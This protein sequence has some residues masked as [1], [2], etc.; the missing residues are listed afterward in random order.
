MKIKLHKHLDKKIWNDDETMR[1]IVRD[2]LLSIAWAYI[3]Y[4]RNEYDLPIKNSDVKDILVVGSI[5]QLFYDKQ[6]DIDVAIVLDT[7][8]IKTK[9]TDINSLR[10]LKLYYYDWAMFHIC[11]IYGRKI[12]LNI[13]SK[14]D[15]ECEDRDV[16]G[17]NFSLLNNKWLFKRVSISE[18]ELIEVEKKA[19]D[20]YNK[21]LHDYK[22]IKSNKFPLEDI[23]NFYNNIIFSKRHEL[24][25]NNAHSI[26]PVYMAIRQFKHNGYI[27]KLR[28]IAIKKETDK[29]VLK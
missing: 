1:P 23:K 8:N 28:E 25:N 10:Q 18:Q 17:P 19:N 16:R 9:F 15:P 21:I 26:R 7:K 11:K 13:R 20:V 5:T 2:M 3:D 22:I 24:Y 12:D 29:Y 6:S 27:K 14:D 4:V